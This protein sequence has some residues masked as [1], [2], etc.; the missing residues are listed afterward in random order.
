MKRS[1]RVLIL[2]GLSLQTGSAQ[3]PTPTV[4]PSDTSPIS[5]LAPASGSPPSGSATL[6]LDYLFNRKPQ[7]GAAAQ[8]IADAAQEWEN[9]VK[10]LDVLTPPGLD[11]PIRRD[12]FETYLDLPE[13]TADRIKQYVDKIGQISNLLKNGDIG[14]AARGLHDLDDDQDLDAG[15]CRELVH[16]VE[17]IIQAGR[18]AGD[19]DQA[20]DKLR[21][22]ITTYNWNADRMPRDLRDDLPVP[23]APDAVVAPGKFE[24]SNEQAKILDARIH[25]KLNELRSSYQMEQ[26]KTIF[27]GY[28]TILFS[29]HR[30]DQVVLAADF[31]RKLCPEEGCPASMNDEVDASLTINQQVDFDLRAFQHR[32][33]QGKLAGATDCLARAFIGNPGRPGLQG[34]PRSE[35]QRVSE[36]LRNLDALKTALES[37]DFSAVR[38]R[39]AHLQE[40]ATDFDSTKPMALM[41]SAKVESKLHL[42]QARL[43]AHQGN[44]GTVMTELESA[45]DFWPGNPGLQTLAESFFQSQDLKNHALNEFDRLV[46]EQNYRAIFDRQLT[47]AAAIVGDALREQ[48]L[49]T[50]LEK[51]R[52]AQ[53]ASE[54]ADRLALTGNVCGAWETIDAAVR[55]WPDDLKLNRLL[56]DLSVREPDFV[57]A[58]HKAREAEA[59][60]EPGYSLTWYVNAQSFYPRSQIAS[61]G[62]DR[63]SRHILASGPVR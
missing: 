16:R 43:P 27:A 3:N 33:G 11:D 30:H 40:I 58:I 34:V 31:Y 25:L 37:R 36:Y 41:E 59:Q 44:L 10:A 18:I 17:S 7:E 39:V 29:N 13:V 57:S 19:L 32:A 24:L 23:D 45:A 1:I 15:V 20:N 5:R 47:L 9:K 2:A 63:V 62:I 55:D 12:Q 54:T 61:Q 4:T 48:Q 49:R 22:Q 56:T 28:V 53:M 42:D 50:A 60:E 51:V 14:S 52:Q 8:S 46:K 35:K 6:T 21:D 26:A 38:E